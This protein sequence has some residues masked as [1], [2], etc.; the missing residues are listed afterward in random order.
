MDVMLN[1]VLYGLYHRSRS[2]LRKIRRYYSEMKFFYSD[3]DNNFN[4]GSSQC[5]LSAEYRSFVQSSVGFANQDS[6]NF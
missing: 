5:G 1:L 3:I 6:D 4:C 2:A